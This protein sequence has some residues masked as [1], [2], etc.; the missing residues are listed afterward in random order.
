MSQEKKFTMIYYCVPE[1][2]DDIESPNAFGYKLLFNIT[3][4]VGYVIMLNTK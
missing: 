2:L 4:K 1:D 3:L